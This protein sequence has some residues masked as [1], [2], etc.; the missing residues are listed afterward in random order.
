MELPWLRRSQIKRFT[1]IDRYAKLLFVY[2]KSGPIVKFLA[3]ILAGLSL[4]RLRTGI[5][6][7]P[8]E[9]WA[10]NYYQKVKLRR[11]PK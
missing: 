1:L 5:L 7:F 6:A 2:P 3:Y 9:I 11:G 4:I 10:S 8:F